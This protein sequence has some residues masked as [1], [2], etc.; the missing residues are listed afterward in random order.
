MNL[1]QLIGQIGSELSETQRAQ[2]V[3]LFG[4]YYSPTKSLPKWIVKA[5]FGAEEKLREIGLGA[6]SKPPTRH[7]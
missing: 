6:E 2:V 3:E 4:Q 7:I 5:I 1:H